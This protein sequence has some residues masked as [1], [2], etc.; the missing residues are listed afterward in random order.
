MRKSTQAFLV[1]QLGSPLGDFCRVRN[2]SRERKV[3]ESSK[4]LV[5][6]I[7]KNL[8]FWCY[9]KWY[10]FLNFN[11]N[12]QGDYICRWGHIIHFNFLG[13]YIQVLINS[14]FL[15]K[16]PRPCLA[17]FC[18]PLN[19]L[20]KSPPFLLISIPVPLMDYVTKYLWEKYLVRD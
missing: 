16:L 14:K 1:S 12:F 15:Q 4:K 6:L 19:P 9:F 11:F 7:L 3:L 2:K 17:T 20:K 8:Y 13:K 18:I 5:K 10:G